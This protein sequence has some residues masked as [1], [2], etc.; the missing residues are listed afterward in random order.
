MTVLRSTPNGQPIAGSMVA[1]GWRPALVFIGIAA[2]VFGIVFQRDI[3]GAV[4][5]WID[6]TAYN[7]CFLIVPLIGFLLWERRAVIASVS[8][9][10]TLWPLVLM[11]LL[12][13]LWLIVAILDIQEARQLLLVAMFEVV[14]LVALG[15]RLFWLLLAPLLFLFFL[16]PSGAFLVPTLQKITAQISIAGLDLLHIPV[17]S[18][19]FMIEIPE[20]TFEIAEACAGLRFLIASI[21]FG[22]FFAVVMYQSVFRRALFIAL[23][24]AVPIVA[25][26]LRALGII[27]LAHLEGSAAAVEAD[28]VLYGWFFFTLVIIIL[29]AIGMTFAQKIDRRIPARSTGWSTPA[30]W[31]FAMAIPAA[32][33]LAVAGPAYAARLN[34]LYPPS[35]LPAAQAPRIAAPWHGVSDASADWRPAVYGADRELL[36]GFEEPGSGVVIRYV[37]LYRLWAIGDAL[38]TTGN[39]LVDDKRWHITG[40]GRSEADLGGKPTMVASTEIVSGQRRRLVWSFYIVDGRIAAGLFETKLLRARAV[41]LDREPVAAFVAISASMDDPKDPAQQQLTRFLTASQPF[42]QY[43]ARLPR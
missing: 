13:A 43:L 19:G 21:V 24:V 28:H 41:L 20:G 22:C 10:P 29:I 15:P 17:F 12:S 42:T 6:S 23:S 18:D 38:T 31:R 36:D 32:V 2:V 4:Q 26:G 40:Y 1:P 9:S 5:V 27:V 7:H 14:L 8:P 30:A 11:P 33:L 35:P 37:A 3:S 39:R 25:N 16:V 34:A